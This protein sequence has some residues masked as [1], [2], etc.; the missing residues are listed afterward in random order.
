[1][2]YKFDE[3]EK[4][5]KE[6]EEWLIKELAGIRTGRASAN[7]LDSV[8]VELYGAKTPLNQIS[9]ITSEDA[10][11]LRISA[12]DVNAIKDIEKAIAQ[13]DLGVS[14]VND[15]KGLRVIFPDLTSERREILS[16]QV[17]KK[18]E[19][20]KISMRNAREKVWNN[21]Q[22]SEK[23]GNM[24]EDEK[25]KSKEDMQK[26]FDS[27]QKNLETLAKNKDTEIRN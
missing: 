20:A 7:I 27:Y 13:A 18:L 11:T 17:G 6:I 21:I 9:S 14:L 10:K 24:N 15:G 26:I 8:R 1:M 22:E 19:E 16:K 4:N 23:A 12:W 25:F 5:L 3:F 2:I